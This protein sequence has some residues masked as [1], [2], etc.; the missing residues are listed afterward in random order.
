MNKTKIRVC[1]QVVLCSK[2]KK[3]KVTLFLSD[4]SYGQRLI[5]Y[6]NGKKYAFLNLLEDES[7]D[8]FERMLK[9]VLQRYNKA[10]SD[11]YQFADILDKT[12]RTTFDEIEGHKINFLEETKKDVIFVHH[13]ILKDFWLHQN[14]LQILKRQ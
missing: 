10:V 6:D 11:E 3:P 12:F 4:F 2:C 9:E 8:D 14:H 5:A 1:K 13:L 7:F